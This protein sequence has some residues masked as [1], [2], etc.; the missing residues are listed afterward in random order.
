MKTKYVLRR[1][2]QIPGR[3]WRAYIEQTGAT[4]VAPSRSA[5]IPKISA[6]LRA[7]NLPPMVN[8]EDDADNYI[9]A[10]MGSDQRARR[11]KI[12]PEGPVPER[13]SSGISDMLA[14][15]DFVRVNGFT[16]VSQEE[17]ERRAAI[18]SA[19]P[20]LAPVGGC[21]ACDMA[22]RLLENT[23]ALIGGKTTSFDAQL[24]KKACAVCGCSS[25]VKVHLNI[26]SG[27]RSAEY[28]QWCWQNKENL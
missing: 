27:Y 18:C 22:R 4:L 11:C 5:L 28:P 1:R 6:H 13:V 24:G 8:P 19:C 3:D 17:A 16:F 14:F 23:T 2:D 12:V 9:C 7:N 10:A 15:V 21:G 26:K 25:K 20:Y